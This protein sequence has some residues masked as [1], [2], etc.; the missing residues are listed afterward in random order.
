VGILLVLLHPLCSSSR[1]SG[2]E[3]WAMGW[4]ERMSVRNWQ[5][6]SNGHVRFIL[7]VL[8]SLVVTRVVIPF[9]LGFHLV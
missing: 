9:V 4:V 8:G 2:L 7:E 1:N 5:V 6:M 3:D